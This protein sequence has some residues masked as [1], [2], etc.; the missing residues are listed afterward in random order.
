MTSITIHR[1]TDGQL[2]EK[3]SEKHVMILRQIGVMPPMSKHP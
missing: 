2:V 1:V 3:W